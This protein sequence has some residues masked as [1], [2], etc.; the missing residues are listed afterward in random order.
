MLAN[1]VVGRVTVQP[2]QTLGTEGI[3][4]HRPEISLSTSKNENLSSE[5]PVYHP[6]IF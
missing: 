1:V 5:A 3:D 6:Y 2:G 4:P